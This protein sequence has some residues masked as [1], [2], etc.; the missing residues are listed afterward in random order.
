M[1]YGA[2]MLLGRYDADG[3]LK[4]GGG[5]ATI[6]MLPG[7]VKWEKKTHECFKATGNRPAMAYDCHWQQFG[8]KFASD[9]V[10]T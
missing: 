5:N 6:L 1:K 8:P 10:Y 9:D 7:R 2:M 3:L 4:L